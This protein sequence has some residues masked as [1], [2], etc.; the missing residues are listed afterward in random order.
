LVVAPR[1]VNREDFFDTYPKVLRKVAPDGA[2]GGLTAVPDSFVPII[3]LVL[4]GIDIDLIFV[5][6]ATLHTIPI[7]LELKDNKLLDNL[8]QAGV[9][10]ITGPVCNTSL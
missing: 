3:K 1:H 8:D 6:I 7:S 9:R 10:A 4:S 5:S 2:L